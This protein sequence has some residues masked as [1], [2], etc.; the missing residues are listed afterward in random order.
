MLEHI[1]KGGPLMIPLVICSLISF[2]VVF[3]RLMAFR[4]NR[5]VQARK[6]IGKGIRSNIEVRLR[7]SAIAKREAGSH[8]RNGDPQN[9]ERVL[10]SDG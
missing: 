4:A 1:L 3:D 9:F 7:N 5:Q 2:A 10:Q 6:R 8:A